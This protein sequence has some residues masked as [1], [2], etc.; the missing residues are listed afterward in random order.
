MSANPLGEWTSPSGAPTDVTSVLLYQFKSAQDVLC[1]WVCPRTMAC[2]CQIAQITLCCRLAQPHHSWNPC[3]P[4]RHPIPMFLRGRP[5]HLQVCQMAL[6]LVRSHALCLVRKTRVS[7]SWEC[8]A[9]FHMLSTVSE[10]ERVLDPMLSTGLLYSACVL[11][12]VTS[13]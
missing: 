11:G 8:L 10:H 1:A 4:M 12:P 3:P 13:R 2:V 6:W 5:M 9:G 7:G